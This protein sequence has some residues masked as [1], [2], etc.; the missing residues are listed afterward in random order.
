MGLSA[1]IVALVSAC[2]G[3][4]DASGTKREYRQYIAAVDR[5]YPRLEQAIARVARVQTADFNSCTVVEQVPPSE[6][7][8]DLEL[9]P[10]SRGAV[11]HAAAPAYAQ[12][13]STL[14]AL[15]ATDRALAAATARARVNA[16]TLDRFRGVHPNVCA[17]LRQWLA[18]HR[19][20]RRFD[21]A[22]AIGARAE[23]YPPRLTGQLE[24]KEFVERARKV[25]DVGPRHAERLRSAIDITLWG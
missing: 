22:K 12:L 16:A 25:L 8:S 11:F 13:A 9:L 19:P 3:T 5:A 1:G 6:L 23:D 2:G 24:M 14:E 10:V 15:H 18:G 21:W 4:T 20:Q 17:A 7:P